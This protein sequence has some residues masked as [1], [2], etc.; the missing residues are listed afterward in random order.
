MIVAVDTISNSIGMK[1]QIMA[2]WFKEF[3]LAVFMQTLHAI[4]LF[5]I[6]KMIKAIHDSH[7]LSSVMEGVFIIML[8]SGLVRFEKLFKKLFGVKD[9]LMGDLKGGTAKVFGAAHGIQQGVGSVIDNSK[10]MSS[11]KKNTKKLTNEKAQI[12]DRFASDGRFTR[13]AQ[14]SNHELNVAQEHSTGFKPSLEGVAPMPETA[15]PLS[16]GFPYAKGMEPA[17]PIK[18][19]MLEQQKQL[20][21]QSMRPTSYA[22]RLAAK[23]DNDVIPERLS[24]LDK[25]SPSKRQDELQRQKDFFDLD[26]KN[27]SL[28]DTPRKNIEA[29]AT[30]GDEALNPV[31][32][33]LEAGIEAPMEELGER[34]KEGTKEIVNAIDRMISEIKTLKTSSSS[35]GGSGSLGSADEEDD[36][37]GKPRKRDKIRADEQRLQE[38]YEEL[39][40]EESNYSSG[41]LASIMGGASLVGGI[42]LGLGATDDWNEVMQIGG[43]ATKGIDWSMEKAGSK[44]ARNTRKDIYE[45][46]TKQGEELGIEGMKNNRAILQPK[47]EFTV[48]PFKLRQQSITGNIAIKNMIKGDFSQTMDKELKARLNKIEE[49]V[50]GEGVGKRIV[51]NLKQSTDFKH[52]R[53]G[54][55]AEKMKTNYKKTLNDVDASQ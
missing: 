54:E 34:S 27:I 48:N 35:S 30:I 49:S 14:A 12:M 2:N 44:G 9:G 21:S 16:G 38:I 47:S 19:M 36:I 41:R 31:G 13:G 26:K 39:A 24:G 15:Q 10:K 32:E 33:S 52:V 55:K 46:S 8:T 29:N 50:K 17:D 53:F 5:I 3:M 18:E 23:H 51:A 45:E 1:T 28:Q 42:G 43:Y 37:S 6:L 22:D 7:S 11:A 25:L 40:T 4:F 20:Q